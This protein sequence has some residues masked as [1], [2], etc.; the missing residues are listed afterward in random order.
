MN[1]CA[2]SKPSWEVDIHS[3]SQEIK[4]EVQLPQQQK[5]AFREHRVPYFYT[6]T[7]VTSTHIRRLL[8]KSLYVVV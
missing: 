4:P 6:S 1:P 3:T 7:T 2:W 8:C 5:L